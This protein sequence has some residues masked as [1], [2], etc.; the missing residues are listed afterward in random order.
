MEQLPI[1][2][3]KAQPTTFDLFLALAQA[4][5][6]L[7]A[8]LSHKN[9]GRNPPLEQGYDCLLPAVFAAKFGG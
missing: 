7:A 9:R 5:W 2:D 1:P 8:Q 6:Q 4:V 3:L